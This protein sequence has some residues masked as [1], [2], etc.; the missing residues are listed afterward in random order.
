MTRS[1]D[2]KRIVEPGIRPQMVW[3]LVVVLFLSTDVLADA[4]LSTGTITLNAV[5]QMALE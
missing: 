5:L 4:D 3:A 1:G 2:G